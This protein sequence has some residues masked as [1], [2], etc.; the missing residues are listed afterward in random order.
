[1]V[2]LFERLCFLTQGVSLA[3]AQVEWWEKE[4]VAA[5]PTR[6]AETIVTLGDGFRILKGILAFYILSHLEPR[7]QTVS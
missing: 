4:E 7:E 3:G 5:F 2:L 6:A 1:M